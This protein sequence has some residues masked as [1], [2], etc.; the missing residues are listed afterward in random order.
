MRKSTFLTAGW[1]WQQARQ[2]K[3]R[4]GEGAGRGSRPTKGHSQGSVGKGRLLGIS[5]K[6]WGT[7]SSLHFPEPRRGGRR[8]APPASHTP[9][10]P[11]PRPSPPPAGQACTYHGQV[12]VGGIELQVDLA[13]DGRLRVLVVVLA[14]LRGARG[15]HGGRL[16]SGGGGSGAGAVAV[17]LG[18]SEGA[19]KRWRGL[20]LSG[21]PGRVTSAGFRPSTVEAGNRSDSPPKLSVIS[22]F[23]HVVCCT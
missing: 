6:S 3:E 15:R 20:A 22:K 17:A 1:Y 23:F 5:A 10:P 21:R 4:G 19:V 13:V 18:R 8:E 16:R 12:D 7:R 2:G 11:P 9:A 14:H